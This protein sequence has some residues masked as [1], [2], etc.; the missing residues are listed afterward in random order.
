M[1]TVDSCSCDIFRLCKGAPYE[2]FS[3]AM[4]RFM[5]TLMATGTLSQ[6]LQVDPSVPCCSFFVTSFYN[7]I[8]FFLRL[9]LLVCQ[10]ESN[11]VCKKNPCLGSLNILNLLLNPIHLVNFAILRCVMFSLEWITSLLTINGSISRELRLQ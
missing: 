9:T 7:F 10:Q 4:A 2:A 11:S 8:C 5:H 1:T 3:A 6:S